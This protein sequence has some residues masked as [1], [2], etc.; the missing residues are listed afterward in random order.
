MSNRYAGLIVF[1]LTASV[2]LAQQSSGASEP[3]GFSTLPHRFVADEW[4]IW[5]SPFRSGTYTSHTVKKYGVPFALLSG[6]LIATD[7]QTGDLLPNTADQAVWSG[8]VS[9]L[10]AW[11]SLAAMAGATYLVGK[12]AGDDHAK[13]AGMLGLEALGHTQLV[14]FTLK[15][16]TNRE[17]PLD[18]DKHGSFWEGG[19]SFPSGHAASSFS[20]A[21]VF[22]YE[23]R[24]HIVVPI[25]AYSV[26]GLVSA[27]RV[28]AR[29]HW[30]SDI[31]VGDSLGFLIG[32]F[33][34]KRNHDPALPG[35]P[36]SRKERLIPQVGVIDSSITLSW[37]P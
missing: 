5:S 25:A 18:H 26:A 17:R 23:Y 16:L 35:S 6:A 24:N 37:R 21:T 4:R 10:G 34:Y 20:V 31:A 33:V 8:R 22:A 19:T 7:R 28:S 36:V 2:L 12:I 27:S 15:Q 11:Y 29:R 3:V 14:V 32:R 1:T 9:Q 30:V 13:E